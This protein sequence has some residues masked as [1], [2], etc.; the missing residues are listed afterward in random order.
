PGGT[1]FSSVCISNLPRGG[2]TVRDMAEDLQLK[3]GEERAVHV[4]SLRE[5]GG[6]RHLVSGMASAVSVRKLWEAAPYPEDD[7]DD[8][9]P[10]PGPPPTRA[11]TIRGTAPGGA[12][13]RIVPPEGE[14]V[15]VQV[16]VSL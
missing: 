12:T 14:P 7:Q 5:Q 13:V 6:W 11:L 3:V 9:G 15:E 8:D 2:G 4:P 10:A 1:A 16:T